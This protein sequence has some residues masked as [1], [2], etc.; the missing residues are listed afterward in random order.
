VYDVVP[1]GNLW[2]AACPFDRISTSAEVR[3]THVIPRRRTWLHLG[4]VVCDVY[5]Q[6]TDDSGNGFYVVHEPT[7]I[8]VRKLQP[9]QVAA[10]KK[11]PGI[12]G[13]AFSAPPGG[14]HVIVADE[15]GGAVLIIVEPKRMRTMEIVWNDA[16]G[17]F[18]KQVTQWDWIIDE[19]EFAGTTASNWAK[20]PGYPCLVVFLTDTN[21]HVFHMPQHKC[22][23]R[24][25]TYY[26]LAPTGS[27]LRLALDRQDARVRVYRDEDMPLGTTRDAT[28]R[29]S[30]SVRCWSWSASNQ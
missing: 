30:P 13:P 22:W 2:G 24:D 27:R 25:I 20:V 23:T 3:E 6:D 14:Y 5:A 15:R 28:E 7:A 19:S 11:P 8:A 26:K 21:L 9:S 4:A 29:T 10:G 17:S 18:D 1:K 16:I 12:R